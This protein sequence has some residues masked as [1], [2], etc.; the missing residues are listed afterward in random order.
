MSGVLSACE[1]SDSLW[2]GCMRSGLDGDDSGHN[3][4]FFFL[5]HILPGTTLTL[6]P[7][8]QGAAE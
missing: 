4:Q 6:A 1:L 3:L 5:N 2:L 7:A 8:T